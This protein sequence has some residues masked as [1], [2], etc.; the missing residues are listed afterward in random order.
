VITKIIMQLAL[1]FIGIAAKNFGTIAPSASLHA[2]L[3]HK[4][5]IL[6]NWS[7]IV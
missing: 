4:N 5:Y 7:K 6:K 3:I 2:S 1:S